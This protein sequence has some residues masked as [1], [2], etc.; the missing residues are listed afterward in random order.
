MGKRAVV[1]IDAEED[2]V[3]KAKNT[4]IGLHREE[5]LR[6]LRLPTGHSHQTSPGYRLSLCLLLRA[7]VHPIQEQ[8]GQQ[9][10][11]QLVTALAEIP[12]YKQSN[13]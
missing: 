4:R 11:M 12:A 13:A 10:E 2:E 3:P 8:P 5:G 1:E 6:S 7:A 9:R